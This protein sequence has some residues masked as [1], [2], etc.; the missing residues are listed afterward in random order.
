MD[1]EQVERNRAVY[2]SWY[3]RNAERER[4]ES[5]A[6]Y[7]ANRERAAANRKAWDAKNPHYGQQW[8]ENN[9]DRHNA[10]HHR[11]RARERAAF[12]EDVDPRVVYY[13]D[14]GTCWLCWLQVPR[15]VGDPLSPSLDHVVPL[16]KGGE[17]SYANVRLAHS[18]CNARKGAK[19][20]S[21]TP[22]R[23]LVQASGVLVTSRPEQVAPYFGTVTDASGQPSSPRQAGDATPVDE[24]D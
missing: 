7:H 10:K 1:P 20:V 24:G 2:R 23:P 18:I 15:V 21:S 9:R 14:G 6:W 11:R 13:R 17:H 8:V 5:L 19:E 16:S 3:E 4:A 12:V 22:G